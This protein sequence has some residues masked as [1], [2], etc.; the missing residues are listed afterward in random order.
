MPVYLSQFYIWDLGDYH[1]VNLQIQV[2]TETT[3][4]LGLHLLVPLCPTLTAG[5]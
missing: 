2:P 1:C 5:L 3:P 4:W